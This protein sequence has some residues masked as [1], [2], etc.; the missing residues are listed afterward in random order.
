[1]YEYARTVKYKSNGEQKERECART[2]AAEPVGDPLAVG[3]H[4]VGARPDERHVLH[5][6]PVEGRATGSYEYAF[7]VRV[8]YSAQH[9]TRT[10]SEWRER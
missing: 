7:T 4:E 5:V 6:A 2:F 9:G 10:G 8:L 3:E 1:M